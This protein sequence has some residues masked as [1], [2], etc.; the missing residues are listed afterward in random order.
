MDDL[1]KDILTEARVSGGRRLLTL[2]TGWI[3]EAGLMHD[4]APEKPVIDR[5]EMDEF[6]A[7]DV[8]GALE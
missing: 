5:V 2:I 8:T 4:P 1:K 3:E 7:I 6:I